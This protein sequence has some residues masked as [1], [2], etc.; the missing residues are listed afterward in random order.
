MID[1]K[2]KKAVF[3]DFGDTLASTVPTY[4]D[5]IR[6][7]LLEIGFNFTEEQY[8]RAFQYADYQIYKNYCYN[9]A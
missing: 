3:F 7:A 6:I 5:R 4:P 2:N 1:L 9:V 8:F